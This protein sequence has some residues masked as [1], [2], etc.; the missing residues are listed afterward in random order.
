[1]HIPDNLT[2]N[3]SPQERHLTREINRQSCDLAGA[4]SGMKTNSSDL[5]LYLLLSSKEKVLRQCLQDIM[6]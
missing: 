6:H 5:T 4:Y 2:S 3:F 1:M